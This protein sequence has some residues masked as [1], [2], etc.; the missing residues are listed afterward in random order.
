MK[1]L[2]IGM[3]YDY[4]SPKNGFSFEHYNFYDSLIK[5]NGGINEIIYFPF[6]EILIKYGIN[7]MNQMLLNEVKR[8]KPDLCFFFIFRNEIKFDTIKKITDSG[9]K[10][11]NWF[12][13]DHWR[14]DIFSKYWAKGFSSFSTTDNNSFEKYKKIGF[15]NV[16]KTQWGVNHFLY[17][18]KFVSKKYDITF[19]GQNYKDRCEFIDTLKDYGFNVSCWG[20]GWGNGRVS[21]DEMIKIFSNSKINLNFSKSNTSLK[22]KTILG[23]FVSLN[24]GGE[25]YINNPKIIFNNI[26]NITNLSKRQIKGRIFEVLGSNGFLISEYVEDLSNYYKIG[27]EIITFKN[28]SE[29]KEKVEYYLENEKEREHIKKAG[30]MRSIKEHTYEK[31]FNDIFKNI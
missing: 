28:R 18:P 10:T 6:D 30:Y 8:I 5:M 11:F 25:L 12:S 23:F 16:I 19:I 9:I 24:L 31:R 27:K 20:S 26:K 15:K 7:K 22:F 2:Y 17:K 4:G 29:L 1:I 14:F 21:Q 3:K 13:D